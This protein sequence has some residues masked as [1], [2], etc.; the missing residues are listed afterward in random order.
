MQIGIAENLGCK[1]R[2]E[3]P[4]LPRI[5]GQA[6]FATGLFEEGAAVPVV[7]DRNLREKKSAMTAQGHYQPVPTNFDLL[8]FNR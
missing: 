6:G 2:Q 1:T 7:L 4:R 8:G 3:C 5:G